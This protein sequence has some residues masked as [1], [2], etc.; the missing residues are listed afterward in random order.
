[1]Q[2]RNLK[3]AMNEM[4][5][6]TVAKIREHVETLLRLDKDEKGEL[7]K[8]GGVEMHTDYPRVIL[9][10]IF[11]QL[12]KDFKP[13]ND[14]YKDLMNRIFNSFKIEK[15]SDTF[16]IPLDDKITDYKTQKEIAKKA[17][18]ETLRKK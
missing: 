11:H 16:E 5:D 10:T 18:D 13:R 15:T 1:M 9:Y 8:F 4:C 14:T 2:R 12:L 17:L 3:D 6:H 7:L